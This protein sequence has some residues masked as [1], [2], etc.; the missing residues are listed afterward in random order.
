MHS[1]WSIASCVWPKRAFA[2][3]IVHERTME[4]VVAIPKQPAGVLIVKEAQAVPIA[5]HG[6]RVNSGRH[7]HDARGP[8]KSS[9]GLMVNVE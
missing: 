6:T 5:S 8:N 2:A 1:S 7:P 9:K 4:R 3:Q